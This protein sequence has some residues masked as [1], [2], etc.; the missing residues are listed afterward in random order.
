MRDVLQANRPQSTTITIW[1]YPD[2]FGYFHDLKHVLYDEGYLTA[3]RPMP[4]GQ[5]I[6][7]SP[8]GTR[9]AAQ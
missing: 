9:S 3:A 1:V 4:D 6:G 5:A 8:R 2:S 7:G